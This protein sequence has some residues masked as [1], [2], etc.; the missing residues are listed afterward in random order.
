M[1][2]PTSSTNLAL[3][4]KDIDACNHEHIIY[5]LLQRIQSINYTVKSFVELQVLIIKHYKDGKK[6]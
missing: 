6:F 3:N 2:L 1:K 5:I 4:I